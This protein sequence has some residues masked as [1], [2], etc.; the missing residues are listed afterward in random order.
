MYW[1]GMKAEWMLNVGGWEIS[2]IGIFYTSFEGNILIRIQS[3][4][5]WANVEGTSSPSL[6]HKY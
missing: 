2:Y 3:V 6:H 5:Y 1:S 4:E